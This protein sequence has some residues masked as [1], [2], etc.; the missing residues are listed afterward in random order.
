MKKRNKMLSEKQY[1]DY[2][3]EVTVKLAKSLEHVINDNFTQDDSLF[4]SFVA[5][6]KFL[7]V[8]NTSMNTSG[9]EMTFPEFLKE[10]N[11]YYQ[12]IEREEKKKNEK[13]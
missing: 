11:S 4:I 12:A 8:F 13:S 3:K 1:S 7:K 2:I 9:Y 5:I 10:I 6:T